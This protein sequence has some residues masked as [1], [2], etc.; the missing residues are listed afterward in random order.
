MRVALASMFRNSANYL[1]RY[2]QQVNALAMVVEMKGHSLRL[3]L[4]EGDSTDATWEG[5][6]QWERELGIPVELFKREHGGRL[7]GSVNDTVRWQQISYVC[8]AILE[9]VTESDEALIYV[10]SDLIWAP[11]TMLA[12]LDTVSGSEIDI[13]AVAPMCFHAAGFFYD[14]WGYRRG[15]VNFMPHPP[16]HPD[17][18]DTPPNFVPKL[19]SIVF[20]LDSAGSCLVM[21]GEVARQC[22]FNPPEEGIVG[23]CKDMAAHGY[24]LWLDPTR[25]VTHP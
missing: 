23:W 21:R 12:M 11:E 6:T 8:N 24:R 17:L 14:V 22:R 1:G 5:L 16:Y 2:F 18:T 9:R 15:G 10:E 25:K 20:E 3:I 19:D 13:P 7:F 4:A